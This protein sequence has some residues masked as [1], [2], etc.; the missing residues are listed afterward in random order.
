MAVLALTTVLAAGCS[1]DG[2]DG[3][4]SDRTTTT[5][6]TTTSADRTTTSKATTTTTAGAGNGGG[7]T[8]TGTGG[9]EPPQTTTTADDGPP[10]TTASTEA[11]RAPSSYAG[12]VAGQAADSDVTFTRGAGI[13]DFKVS[14]LA[15]ECQPLAPTG[16]AKSRTV[17]VAIDAAP[18]AADGSV[19]FTQT[20][21]TYD[22]SLSGSFAADG[23]FA[24]GLFLSGES[25]GFV[26]GGEFAFTAK[27]G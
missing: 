16:D 23:T 11:P 19:M 20:D 5:K 25:E 12:L 13:E 22:P 14:G 17:D 8:T 21:A 10:S 4:A 6:R 18:V 9:G 26:C 1:S 15:I 2:D 3:G 24:G 27:P 7:T